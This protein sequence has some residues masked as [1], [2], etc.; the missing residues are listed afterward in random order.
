ML[1]FILI[2]VSLYVLVFLGFTQNKKY[3]NKQLLHVNKSKQQAKQTKH[4]N[5]E[6]SEC[7]CCIQFLDLK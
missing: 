5:Q 4:K 3:V 7:V 1:L 6:I 2:F